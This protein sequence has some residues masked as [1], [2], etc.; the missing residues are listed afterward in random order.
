MI[1]CIGSIVPRDKPSNISGRHLN[2]IYYAMEFLT[3]SKIFINDI[4]DIV[5]EKKKYYTNM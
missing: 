1:L 2:G 4:V 3:K 5:G